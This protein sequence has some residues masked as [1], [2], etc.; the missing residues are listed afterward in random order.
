VT[1]LTPAFESLRDDVR[2]AARGLARTPGYSVMA[3]LA[4]AIGIGATAAAYSIVAGVLL[5]PLP[6]AEADRLMS[7]WS[8]ASGCDRCLMSYP[9]FEDYH[10]AAD[11][12]DGLA[13]VTGNGATITRPDGNVAVLAAMVTPDFFPLLRATPVLGRTLRAEDDHP[14]AAPVTVLSHA[15]WINHFGGDPHIIGESLE[16]NGHSF[17][18][19]GVLAPGQALPEWVPGAYSD[20]FVPLSSV[21]GLQLPALHSRESHSDSRTIARLKPGVTLEQARA[22]LRPIA[23]RLAAAYPKSDSG[24]R[25]DVTP[26]RDTVIGDARPAL[27]VLAAAVLLVFLLACA[28]V[29]NLALLRA[30]ARARELAV[31]AALGARWARVAR[32][33]AAESALLALAGSLGGAILATA[34]VRAFVA[35]SPGDIPR[36]DEV[37]VGG[38]TLIALAVAAV[39]ATAVCTLAPVVIVGRADLVPA[40]KSGGRGPSAGRGTLRLR[41]AIVTAQFA[42]AMVLVVGAG[43]LIRSFAA[44]RGADPGFDPSHLLIVN[45]RASRAT[46]ARMA[47]VQ[48]VNTALMLPGVESIT[49]VNHPPLSPGGTDTPVGADGADPASD[50]VESGYMTVSQSYFSVMRIPMARGR[51]FTSADSVWPPRVAIVSRA[52]AQHYWPGGDPIGHRITVVDAAHGDPDFGKPMTATVVGVAGDVRRY[53]R[54]DPPARLVYVPANPA[55]GGQFV[56][57]TV[58]PPGALMAAIRLA[59]Q[60]IDP[61]AVIEVERYDDMAAAG[62]IRERF[63][64][65]LLGAFSIVAF[66]LAA[67]GIYGVI[68]YTVSRRTAEMGIRVALGARPGDIIGLMIRRALALAFTGIGLGIWGAWL[69]GRAMR[70]MLFGVTAFDPVTFVGVALLL[71]TTALAASYLPARRAART[72]PLVALRAE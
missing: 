56:V 24:V 27:A 53:S 43:L 25:A 67:L 22:R 49:L 6:F 72:D 57:R 13:F 46:G 60:P 55:S 8:A 26:L 31:R 61:A 40:L 17:T 23:A 42:L 33:L 11:V 54:A 1:V 9:D 16:L 12:F 18:I 28:D 38:G 63:L 10:S 69:L 58:G 71:G 66:V 3:V 30:T 44:L 36:A 68:A 14:G 59:L 41:G 37:V 70:G 7:V 19:A 51:Q 2:Q 50:S 48:R 4:L 29:A 47:E 35:A 20:L 45:V 39:I 65:S 64:M 5:A 32:Y 15:L 62:T 34:G 21:P 52:A